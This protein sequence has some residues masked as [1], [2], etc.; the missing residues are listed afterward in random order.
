MWNVIIIVFVSLLPLIVT[1]ITSPQDIFIT[2]EKKRETQIFKKNNKKN[3]SPRGWAFL[4][5]I[6][7]TALFAFLQ[8]K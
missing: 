5:S 8:H 2:N 4:A 1:L 7:L 3:L 6:I